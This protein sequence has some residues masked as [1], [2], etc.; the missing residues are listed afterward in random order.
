MT[1]ASGATGEETRF[2]VSLTKSDSPALTMLRLG[3]FRGWVIAFVAAAAAAVVLSPGISA[4]FEKDQETQSAQWIEGITM[5][6][7]W[8]LPVDD[9]GGIDRKPPLYY[10]L[11]ALVVKAGAG[12]V[13]EVNARFVSFLSAILIAT[14][15]AWWSATFLGESTGWLALAF[16]L[17][18]YGFASRARV[19]LTDMLLSMLLFAVWLCVYH[20]MEVRESRGAVLAGGVLLGLAVLTKGPVAIVLIGVAGLIYLAFVWRSPTRVLRRRWPWEIVAIS[21]AIGACWYVPAFI[22]HGRRLIPVFLS[23]NFGHFLPAGL[24]GTGEASR[25]VW[26][27]AAR[28]FGGSMPMSLLVGAFALALWRGDGDEHA[29]KPLLF[30]LAFVLGVLFFFSAASAKRDDYILPAMPGLAILFAALFTGA[31][32]APAREASLAARVRDITTGAIAAGFVA[33]VL[34]ALIFARAPHSF[35]AL[36]ARMQSSDAEFFAL[37]MAGMRGPSGA[38]ALFTAGSIL[39]ALIVFAAL[40]RRRPSFLKHRALWLGSGLALIG[41]C[42]STLFAGVLKP[43]LA[44]ER[45]MHIFARE[46]QE[47]IGNA[48][49]YVASGRS[50]ELSYYDGHAVWGLN[51]A[52]PR[53]VDAHTPVYVVARPREFP[54]IPGAVRSRLRLVM[55]S[56]LIGGG[57]PPALYELMPTVSEAHSKSVDQA[58]DKAPR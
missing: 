55:R 16:V 15:V 14:A 8:L 37:F 54:R 39:G 47:R 28:M 36:S 34:A 52:G 6:G 42:G 24:G 10:W 31:A 11:S 21:I 3:R 43:G 56:H 50:Y 46:V 23:E 2:E 18:T 30:Q 20:L 45:S 29:R 41:L 58:P 12:V 40:L 22:E 38:Y 26:Y 49:L 19:D 53:A 51:L 25:P 44:R 57:G 32:I 17:G 48:P 1:G 33:L 4:P 5:R 7:Q 27:I 35:A 13:D 9:Y